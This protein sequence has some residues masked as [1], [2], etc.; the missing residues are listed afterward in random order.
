MQDP[1]NNVAK[2]QTTSKLILLGLIYVSAFLASGLATL[3]GNVTPKIGLPLEQALYF[4]TKPFAAIFN[5]SD[6]TIYHRYFLL[7]V[8]WML[9][10]LLIGSWIRRYYLKREQSDSLRKHG[11]ITLLTVAVWIIA[12]CALWVSEGM[13]FIT[14]HPGP[15]NVAAISDLELPNECVLQ[16]SRY[17]GGLQDRYLFAVYTCENIQAVHEV[18]Q[19]SGYQQIKYN[20]RSSIPCSLTDGLYWWNM[21]QAKEYF[22][23]TNIGKCSFVGIIPFRYHFVDEIFVYVK[24]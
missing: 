2:G 22:I 17:V 8:T 9:I 5:L 12:S 13:G 11:S 7:P 16:N 20:K 4:P 15:A 10:V 23:L 1:N 18:M 14:T 6:S 19:L 24:M 21:D 3:A